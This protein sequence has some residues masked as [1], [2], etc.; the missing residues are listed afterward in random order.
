MHGLAHIFD[1][2]FKTVKDNSKL[3][4]TWNIVGEYRL[5]TFMENFISTSQGTAEIYLPHSVRISLI[6]IRQ[7]RYISSVYSKTTQPIW[8]KFSR[9]LNSDAQYNSWVSNR[10]WWN[11]QQLTIPKDWFPDPNRKFLGSCSFNWDLG[12]F[13]IDE[14][15]STVVKST[16]TGMV[17]GHWCVSPPISASVFENKHVGHIRI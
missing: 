4:Q 9:S 3:K 8:T 10:V 15:C 12:A 6:L 7:N 5:S 1:Y 17:I 13:V 14:R 11:S 16:R 2:N